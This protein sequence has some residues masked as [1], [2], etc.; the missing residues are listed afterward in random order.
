MRP[1][2]ALLLFVPA[3]VL[4]ACGDAPR[5]V[6]RTAPSGGM[7]QGMAQAQ[8]PAGFQ[9]HFHSQEGWVEEQPSNTMRLRQY[10]LP[11][12][13]EAGDA[14]LVVFYFGPGGGGGLED[15]LSRWAGQMAQPDGSDPTTMMNRSERSLASIKVTEIALTGTYAGDM[16][17]GAGER[18]TF[19]GYALRGAVLE[20]EGGPYYVKLTGP[21]ATVARW[22]ASFK[23]FVDQTD[24]SSHQGG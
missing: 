16:M 21:E 4:A 9:P 13:G 22:A 6:E 20:C 10:R 11:G 2:P 18:P 5:P 12:E 24:P 23:A 1:T 17:P 14:S 15:N 7:G 19:P 8:A 3:L